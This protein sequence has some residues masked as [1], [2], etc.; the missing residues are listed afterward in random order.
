MGPFGWCRGLPHQT[1]GKLWLLEK[2]RR[3]KLKPHLWQSSAKKWVCDVW[4]SVLKKCDSHNCGSK[5]NNCQKN[6]SMTNLG[7]G[8]FWS[9]TKCLHL[10]HGRYSP[11]PPSPVSLW[12][13]ASQLTFSSLFVSLVYCAES[14]VRW[15]VVREKHCWMAADSADKSKRTGRRKFGTGFC[16]TFSLHTL[17]L[18]SRDIDWIITPT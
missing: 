16:H 4:D 3:E 8:T 1:F 5:P 12:K 7:H 14:T 11:H 10:H 13:E 9:R 2:V 15:F 17:P 6:Y 18:G